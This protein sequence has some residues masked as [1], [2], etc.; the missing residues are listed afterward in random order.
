MMMGY[1]RVFVILLLL[2]LFVHGSIVA[3]AREE[4]KEQD[5]SL[6]ELLSRDEAVQMAGYG[7]QKLSTV[8]ITGSLHCYTPFH[9]PCPIPG[10]LVGVKCDSYGSEKKEKTSVARG[11]TDEFGDF[12]VDIPSHLHAIPNLEKVCS[13]KVDSIPKGSMCKPFQVMRHNKGLRLSSFGNG[14]RTYTAGNIR[15]HHSPT[16][17]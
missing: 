11:V 10:A 5:T 12:I 2:L 6:L 8:L 17:L 16:T 14:I 7:E 13:V 4:E 1:F 9:A 15:I 3:S